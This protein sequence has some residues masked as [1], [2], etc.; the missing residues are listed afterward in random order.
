LDEKDIKIRELEQRIER[1]EQMLNILESTP[2]V[3]QMSLSR[4]MPEH[5]P[6]DW[7]NFGKVW[8]PRIFVIVLLIGV[9][10][11][12]IAA[13]NAG[14]VNRQAR[15]GIGYLTVVGLLFTGE[16]EIQKTRKALGQV[17][18]GGGVSTG[19]LTVFA[20]SELYS[21]FGPTIAYVQGIL[22][23]LV[24]LFFA[25]RH[26]SESLSILSCIA[27]F[28]LPFLFNTKVGSVNFFIAYSAMIS[29]GFLFY[30]YFRN[31]KYLRYTA[32]GLLH[33]SFIAFSLAYHSTSM[34][35]Y[36]LILQNL[37]YA[38]MLLAQKSHN[39]E[40]VLLIPSLGLTFLWM[41]SVLP[42]KQISASLIV[43]SVIYAGF[44]LAAYSLKESRT[45]YVV[46]FTLLVAAYFIH[47]FSFGV[48]APIVLVEGLLSLY[49]GAREK[50]R[51]M[52]RF[53][54]IFYLAGALRV[55]LNAGGAYLVFNSFRS[56]FSPGS[57][58]SLVLV[59]TLFVLYSLLTKQ[60]VKSIRLE[61]ISRWAFIA[62]F[63]IYLSNISLTVTHG[64]GFST[65]MLVLSLVWILYA[66][67]LIVFGAKLD[68]RNCRM[69]GIIFLFV[70]LC[71]VVL[72]DLPNVTMTVRAI[73]FLA[74]GGIG[75]FVSRLFYKK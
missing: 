14:L 75:V 10:F 52:I 70:S 69:S 35:A 49:L 29:F 16:I 3:R 53:S 6:F 5:K 33:M 66:F 51:N 58:S 28:L 67:G 13:V 47:A 31:E 15:V 62:V 74:L 38:P 12:F 36:V 71:K 20:A 54:L 25:L 9:V 37:V 59:I 72:F 30:S 11:G 55:L 48:Y 44:I 63:L 60:E 2:T 23:I 42:S 56:L 68:S 46:S 7:D 27:G 57:L 26:K 18:I 40:K 73:L 65:T 8:V 17:L 32:L 39:W 24:G 1:I 22:L 61:S 34:F 45:I 50:N 41:F 43:L 64:L 4:K 19:F 21:F